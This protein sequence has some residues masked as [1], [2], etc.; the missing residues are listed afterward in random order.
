MN[1][2]KWI[3]L[4]AALALMGGAAALLTRLKAS[5]KLGRPGVK[6]SPIPGSGR[7]QVDLPERVL[8]YTSEA[9]PVEKK[10]LDWLPQDTSF[11]QRR[12]QAPDGFGASL[13]VVL[14]GRDR[15]SL[16]KTEFCLEGQGWHIDRNASSETTVH[17]DRPCSYDLPVMKFVATKELTANGQTQT[18]RGVYIFWFVADDNQYT[19]RH[20]QRMWWMARDLFFTGVLQRW[21]MISCFTVCAP[22]QE[23]AAFE[24]LKKFMVASVPEFQRVPQPAETA[25]AA[26]P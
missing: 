6:T 26:R 21:A 18:G 14:M 17:M 19:A 1:K 7:L 20:W 2:Q 9:I 23:D 25:R 8:D 10:V 16:H 3:I 13:S 12:Y 5:Q 24:R 4:L 11:G 22:G 15:T